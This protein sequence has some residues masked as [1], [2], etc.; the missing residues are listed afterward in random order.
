MTLITADSA[1]SKT[2]RGVSNRFPEA[3]RRSMWYMAI[4]IAIGTVF[5]VGAT[6]LDHQPKGDDW[7]SSLTVGLVFFLHHVG[8]GLFVSSTAVLFYEWGAH[9]KDALDLSTQLGSLLEREKLEAISHGM[10]ET[11]ESRTELRRV[12]KQFIEKLHWLDDEKG[13]WARDAD[14]AF[15]TLF[16]EQAADYAVRLAK[17]RHDLNEQNRD[18][19]QGIDFTR[20][21]EFAPRILIEQMKLLKERD[22]YDTFSNPKTWSALRTPI[23]EPKA[24]GFFEA[25]GDAVKN[26]VKIRRVFIMNGGGVD[27]YTTNDVKNLYQHYAMA[28]SPNSENDKGGS[29]RIHFTTSEVFQGLGIPETERHYGIFR[30]HDKGAVAFKVVGDDV[31]TFRLVAAPFGS[32]LDVNFEKVWSRLEGRSQT[33]REF[34]DGFIDLVLWRELCLRAS[35]VSLQLVSRFTTWRAL[36]G[37]TRNLPKLRAALPDIPIRHLFVLDENETHE[38][39]VAALR[40]AEGVAAP[41]TKNWQIRTCTRADVRRRNP[42]W[43][44]PHCRFVHSDNTAVHPY[45]FSFECREE[46]CRGDNCSCVTL[47]RFLVEK[48][49]VAMDYGEPF[50]HWWKAD[51]ARRQ[52]SAG[53]HTGMS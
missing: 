19:E 33:A 36:W 1:A 40:G 5:T 34:A 29:Y 53:H 9:A 14:V 17:L 39:V 10:D 35:D 3:W 21:T 15:L 28:D 43:S 23:R 47:A 27:H 51:E 37:D 45:V 49:D 4:G 16:V 32:A 24:Y 38:E 13:N 22:G 26:G 31:A 8:L 6:V 46:T 2:W 11:F 42:K 18:A 12:H 48:T 7:L 52:S 20:T 50:N 41:G 30:H 44:F 25:G